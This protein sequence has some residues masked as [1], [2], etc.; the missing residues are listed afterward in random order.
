MQ[1]L[2][3]WNKDL[4][5]KDRELER[6]KQILLQK[7]EEL[8]NIKKIAYLSPNDIKR[9]AYNGNAIEVLQQIAINNQL[10]PAIYSPANGYQKENKAILNHP[11]Y[12]NIAQKQQEGIPQINKTW[13]S[14]MVS[15]PTKQSSNE[16]RRANYKQQ[17]FRSN[18]RQE[19]GLL[20]YKNSEQNQEEQSFQSL[21]SVSLNNEI[22]GATDMQLEDFF[23]LNC[24]RSK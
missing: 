23:E 2:S 15:P 7:D 10:S 21:S 1:K 4:A 12:K 22:S 14:N 20:R 11:F 8:K 19:P 24:K 17:I 3:K 5:A 6:S 13:N 9:M 16:N 18:E